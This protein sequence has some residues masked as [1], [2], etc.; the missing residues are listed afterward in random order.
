MTVTPPTLP[1]TGFLRLAQV[2]QLVPVSKTVWYEGV[3][4]GRFPKAV[5]LG[6]RTSAY[7]VE[8]IAALIERL[9]AQREEVEAKQ[10]TCL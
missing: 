3:Q 2:L 4:S 8:D 7:R 10:R 9:G 6:P 5:K 1:S